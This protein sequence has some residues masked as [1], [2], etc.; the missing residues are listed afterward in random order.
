MKYYSFL[1]VVAA[2]IL[3]GAA[4]AVSAE[5]GASAPIYET[6]YEFFA[7][8]DF[9][10][11]GRTDL[12][13]V[14]KESGKYRLG[15]QLTPGLFSWVD[16]RP[17]GIKGIA[18]FSM[19]RLL[20]P[21]KEALA[22]TSPDANQI[23]MVDA[24]S[25][26]A[27]GK[28]VTVPFTAALGPNTV[29]A[30]DIGGEGKKGQ[31]DLYVGS[32]YNSPDPSQATLV[33]NDG[34]EFPKLAEE[35]LAGP[36]AR[37]NRL[38]LKAGAPELLCLL[39]HE[40]K[41]DTLRVEELGS[42]KPVTV[43]TVAN[44]PAGSD[45]AVGNF[46]GSPLRDFIFYKPGRKQPDGPAG[47]RIRARSSSNSARPRASTWASRCG[48]WLRSTKTAGRS[49]S[50]SSARAKRPGSSISTEPRRRCWPKVW[51]RPTSCSPARQACRGA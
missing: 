9:D 46:R 34:A 51:R 25:P 24:S 20:A 6:P 40:D 27:S 29:V 47:G 10:H 49:C 12:V 17:S 13:I 4:T 28:P 33:R 42:G 38:S 15:Y 2:S 50:S 45:Y 1:T 3:A 7:S 41:A 30:V 32:I 26:T 36:A 8:G 19:G 16:C 44:L 11:D 35:P 18:G 22:F 14:D 5:Q 43:A 21:D 31:A 39:V 48:G 23:T 37:G